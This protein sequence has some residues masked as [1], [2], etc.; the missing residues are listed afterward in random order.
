[1]SAGVEAAVADAVPR[2]VGPGRRDP[3]PGD[4][5]LGPR[6]GVRAGRLRARRWSAGR[7]TASRAGPARG[8]P[9]PRA[10]A[11]ST[12]CAAAATGT[13]QAAGGARVVAAATATDDRTSG[14]PRRPRRPA[15]ADLHLLPSG[16]AARGPGRADAAHPRRADH[17]RDRP[18]VPGPRAT[19]AQRLVRAKRKIRN[20]GIPYRVPPAHLL[21]ERTAA[22]LAVLYLLFNEGYAATRGADLVRP[23]LCA[24]AIR[25]ART[26]RRADAGRARGARP[27][28][29]DAAA[30]RPA[31][32]PGRRGRR[33]GHAGG[34]G[35]R[36]AGTTRRSTRASRVLDAALRRRR[37]GAVPDPGRDRGAATPRRPT[38]ADTDW[39]QIAA[40]YEQLARRCAV[41]GRRAE[42]GGGGG[43]GRRPGGRAGAGRRARATGALAG[44]HLLPAT[45][46]DLLRRLGRHDE[47]AAPT[48]RRSRSRP[49]D[50]ERR[51]LSRRL[52]EV[53]DPRPSRPTGSAASPCASR[54]PRRRP[55]G[56]SG[57]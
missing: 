39:A 34:P 33:A 3:D 30:R 20:A 17:G 56:A 21:P 24:E 48:A 54:P 36:R 53:T 29:A 51:Y 8:S 6:R 14:R 49:T 55:P 31:R 50:A 32:R 13:R 15:A 19:M 46:A 5:R 47:A 11:P 25:L 9:R 44:Y 41:A 22:V 7:A 1:M 27:A 43:D 37:A 57:P 42:P 35:P 10:T 4:R 28:R 12:G 40:L 23:D 18:R 52:A 38:A 2:G 45:R 26:A 16:A